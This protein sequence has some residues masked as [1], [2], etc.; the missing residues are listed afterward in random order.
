MSRTYNFSAGPAALPEA[1]LARRSRRCWSGARRHASVM[2][3]S[4]RGKE[5]IALAKESEDDMRELLQI[6]TKLQSAFSAGR[7]DAAFRADSDEHRVSAARRPTTSSPAPGARRRPRKP[8]RSVKAADRGDVGV[9]QL[10]DRIPARDTWKLDPNAAYVHYT[11][12]ETIHGVE[13]Q[14]VPDV[15]DVPL[16][17]D[18]SSNILSRPVDVSKFGIIYAGAQKNIGAVR[19]RRHDHARRSARALAERHPEN[20]QLRRAGRQRFDA[21]HAEHVRLVSR[22]RSTFKWLKKRRRTRRRSRRTQHREGRSAVRLHR[23]LG[24]LQQSGREVGRA[25]G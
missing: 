25:R 2:E 13:F 1:V 21:Q 17:A 18:M 10:H 9:D 3:I 5:F 19:S 12:N 8:S 22:R 15:G 24:L 4:H 6:P 20:L 14:D 16:V 7:R 11:P 23:R